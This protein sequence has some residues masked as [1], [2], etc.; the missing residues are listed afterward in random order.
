[1]SSTGLR[2]ARQGRPV[3][4]ELEASESSDERPGVRGL[5]SVSPRAAAAAAAERISLAGPADR[6]LPV[7]LLVRPAGLIADAV[8]RDRARWP[9]WL[10][11]AFAGGIGIYFALP[12]EPAPGAVWGPPAVL[13]LIAW[14]VRLNDAA[15]WPVL[16]VMFVTLGLTVAAV[17]TALVD[18]VLLDRP[19]WAAVEGTVE[20]LERRPADIRV[21]LG[22]ARVDAGRPIEAPPRRVRV[23]ARAWE[24]VPAIGDRIRLRA[25]L[26][27]PPPP[28]VPGGFDFQRIAFFE[29]LEAVGFSIGQPEILSARPRGGLVLVVAS[30]RATVAARLADALPGPTGAVATALIVGDRAGLDDATVAAFRD[31]GLAHLLAISGLHMGLVAGTLFAATRLALCLIPTV[32]LRRPVKKIAALTALA[33]SAAYLLLAGAPVPT[34]RA[35]LMTGVVL[36]AVIVDREAVTLRLVALAALLLL[37]LRP[38]MLIGPSFQLSFAAVI[39]L[40]AA[41]EGWRGNRIGAGYDGPGLWAARVL[42]YG[43]GVAVTSLVATLA[44]APFVTF[45]FQAIA[46]GGLAANLLAVPLTAFVTMPAGIAGLLVMPLG[47]EAWV[48]PAMGAGIDATLA[49][50]DRVVALTGPAASVYPLPVPGLAAVALGGCWVAIWRTALRWLGLVPMLAGAGLWIAVAPPDVLISADGGFAAV[51]A[52]SDGGWAVT[53]RRGHGFLRSV[54]S[55]RWGVT[56]DVTLA[57]WDRTDDHAPSADSGGGAA[58]SLACDDLGC[59]LRRDGMLLSLVTSH[60][61]AL[62]DCGTVDVLIALVRIRTNCGG[63][64][65][66]VHRPDLQRGGAH[67]FWLGQSGDIDGARVETVLGR[68]GE[69]PWVVR[70][71]PR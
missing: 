29:R 9:L 58:R 31:S 10:P 42:R 20:R 8:V 15:L 57:A 39:A 26:S 60:E 51:A 41:H 25:R 13:A 23:V 27:P 63:P 44:T 61:A 14:R 2:G 40:V 19:L 28:S 16:L 12:L 45:H 5:P 7:A 49:V 22:A 38:D 65:V 3:H 54:W 24:T 47:L 35:F 33:G 66:V 53:S 56:D 64:A 50:A 36:I 1:M 17:R 37:F 43:L 21:T 67:A 18:T 48:L 4:G 62:E 11:V 34:Q 71:H 69:R 52:D 55:R 32:A 70:V 59:T 46:L 6:R 30:L 68:R